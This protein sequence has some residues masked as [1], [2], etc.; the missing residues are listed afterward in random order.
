MTQWIQYYY[1]DH[2]N[3]DQGRLNNYKK[4]VKNRNTVRLLQKHNWITARTVPLIFMLGHSA[5]WRA[6]I[7]LAIPVF[8]RKSS[9]MNSAH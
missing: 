5:H 9:T 1:G 3:V 2:S 8:S 4:N 6:S 7:T